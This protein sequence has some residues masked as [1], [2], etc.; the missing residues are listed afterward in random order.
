[1]FAKQKKTEESS[2]YYSPSAASSTLPILH[3]EPPRKALRARWRAKSRLLQDDHGMRGAS[4]RATMFS[5]CMRVPPP[6]FYQDVV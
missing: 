6:S 2:N 5:M 3:M 1:M 4:Y